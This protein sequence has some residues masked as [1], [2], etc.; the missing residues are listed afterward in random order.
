VGIKPRK[1]NIT[2]FVVQKRSTTAR[3]TLDVEE[4]KRTPNTAIKI[5]AKNITLPAV[6]YRKN[7]E[8]MERVTTRKKDTSTEA[9]IPAKTKH[10]LNV[11]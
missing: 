8:G 9:S 3:K 4:L 2:I 1:R 7:L 6:V 11:P 10:V 5:I